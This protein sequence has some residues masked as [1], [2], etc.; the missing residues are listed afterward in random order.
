MKESL[1]ASNIEMLELIEEFLEDGKNVRIKI[2]GNSMLPFLSDGSEQVD[3]SAPANKELRKGALVLFKYG[4]G[5]ILHR[6]IQR[7]KDRLILMGDNI[8]QSKEFITTEQVIGIVRRII[9]LNGKVL[10][11]NSFS[12][13]TLSFCWLLIKPV[14]VLRQIWGRIITSFF[15]T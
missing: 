9:F 3:L 12:W 15:K 6:I 7:K 14:M 11:T 1:V 13:K 10:D 2:K 8:Y 4:N 5:F